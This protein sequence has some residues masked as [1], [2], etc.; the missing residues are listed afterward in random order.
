MSKEQV[1]AKG[2]YSHQ[3][4]ETLIGVKQYI[5]VRGEDGKKRLLLR[6][7]NNRQE[8]CSKFVFILSRLDSKGK[9]LGEERFES[10]NR[11]YKGKETFSFHQKID[12]E[13]KCTDFVVRM[14]YARYGEYVH[15]VENNEVS[16]SYDN[17]STGSKSKKGIGKLKP[18][19]ISGRSFD[20][21]WFFV[22]ISLVILATAFAITGFLLRDYVKTEKDFSLAGVHYKFKDKAK[23]EVEIVGCSDYYR[24]IELSSVIEDDYKVVGIKE[25]AFKKNKTLQKIS[26]DGINIEPEAFRGCTK[27]EAVSISNVSLIGEKAFYGCSKLKSITVNEGK[28]A[29]TIAI[30]SQAFGNCKELISVEINQT[31]IYGEKND[32]LN[33]SLKV[34]E[35]KLKNFAYTMKD[36]KSAYVTKISAL[37]GLENKKASGIKLKSL[38]IE[39]I[40]KIPAYFVTGFESLE[41]VTIKKSEIKT[42]GAEAFKDCKA[43]TKLE[44]KQKIVEIGSYA[45]SNT[46]IAS[47]DLKNVSVLG[48]GVFKGAEY[49]TQANGLGEGGITYIPKNTFEGCKKLTSFEI[50]P[51]ITQVYR[52]AFKGSGLTSFYLPQNVSFSI[53]ILEDCYSLRELKIHELGTAGFVGYFFGIADSNSKVSEISGKVPVALKTITLDNGVEI[54]AHAFKGCTGVERIKLPEGVVSFGKYAFAGCESL[55][56]IEIP[57][58]TLKNIG[59]YAF[60][61]TNLE[62]IE[63]P[64][65]LESI[66]YGALNGCDNLR[67]ITIPFLGGSKNQS[68]GGIGYI[69]GDEIPASL[70]NISLVPNTQ[71]VTLPANAFANCVG[72]TTINIPSS[73]TI[74]GENAFYNCQK[75]ANVDLSQVLSIGNNAFDGCSSLT[76]V[77]LCSKLINVG[78]Y[79]FKDTGLAYIDIPSDVQVLGKGILQGCDN[80]TSLSAPYLGSTLTSKNDAYVSYFFGGEIGY[81]IP[82]SLTSITITKPFENGIIPSFAFYNCKNVVNFGIE[83]GYT[84]I[85]ESAFQNCSS[86]VS[87]DFSNI[88]SIGSAAFCGAGIISAEF[89]DT[90]VSLGAYSFENCT[91]LKNVVLPNG[92]N[93]IGSNT[94]KNTGI[95]KIEIPEGVSS[96]GEYAFAQTKLTEIKIP[97]S[98]SVL[99]YGAFEGCND[100]NKL[101]FPYTYGMYDSYLNAA[102][103]LFKASFPSSLKRVVINKTAYSYIP[104]RAFSYSYELEEVIINADI[105]T[106]ESYTFDGCIG[107]RYVEIPSSVYN[108]DETAF[109]G[110][111]HLYEINANGNYFDAGISSV[112]EYTNG[113][114]PTVVTENGYTFSYLD[115][116]W[117]LVNYPSIKDIE[118]DTSFNY[119]GSLITEYSIP[120]YL[121]YDDDSIESVKLSASV[122]GIGEAIFT[123]CQSLKTV[124][125]GENNSISAIGE[126]T[127]AYCE[128]LTRVSLPDSVE[129]IGANAFEECSNLEEVVFPSSLRRIGSRAF[130]DCEKLNNVKLYEKVTDIGEE[131]FYGC[132]NLYDVY[133]NGTLSLTAG[134]KDNGYVARNAV[135]VH[136]DMNE[137][138]SVKVN[139]DGIGEFRRSGSSWLLVEG[140][141]KKKIELDVFYYDDVKVSEYRIKEGAFAYHNNIEEL[142]IG[143]SV[144]QIQGSAF[145]GCSNIKRIDMSNNYSLKTIEYATFANCYSLKYAFLP[146][147]V[148]TLRDSVF[149]SCSRLVEVSMPKNLVTIG[150]YVF[151]G[152]SSLVSITLNEGVTTIGNY[153][154]DGCVRLYEV[155]DLSPSINVR[156]GESGNGMVGE[157]A[158]TVFTNTNQALARNE[159]DGMKFI[160]TSAYWYLYDF[161]DQGMELIT[162]PNLE[163]SIVILNYSIENGTFKSIIMPKNI[164]SIESNAFANCISFVSIYYKGN[165]SDWSYVDDYSSSSYFRNLYYYSSCVHYDSYRAWTYDANGS[166]T[167]EQCKETMKVTKEPDCY[168]TGEATYYCDCNGCSYN[169]RETIPKTEH[170]FENGIC[171]VCKYQ[172]VSFDE[173][174]VNEY[175][176]SGTLV[177]D[178]FAY[179]K[180]NNRFV[181]LNKADLSSSSFVITAKEKMTVSFKIQASSESYDYIAIYVNGIQRTS[182][183]AKSSSVFE[184]VLEQGDV[185][186][187]SYVK[188]QS[189]SKYDDCGYIENFKVIVKPTSN[190]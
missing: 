152:C 1:L 135:K 182:V 123:S 25:G 110:C 68:T 160:K 4:P 128:N 183:S 147:T 115:G 102:D 132:K 145:V 47:I 142:I 153:S 158:D 12:V 35:L 84:K 20:M 81:G 66:G 167:T 98:V 43:F 171:T 8:S 143:N 140:V 73:I 10:D 154:F 163:G 179:D 67:Y 7:N 100:L 178:D 9:V 40:D 80:I 113:K 89:D 107:L 38:E 144:K 64:T 184:E 24:E 150:S 76:S 30:G 124:D 55:K 44:G 15:N 17:A 63:L 45:F 54:N 170:N 16:V 28:N 180:E 92:L 90:L 162:F 177:L 88:E 134:E 157:Y 74:I 125:F 103:Y 186:T 70:T 190:D 111:Y 155:Y 116:E 60:Y 61:N 18:R 97:S 137:P 57:S 189:E 48:T 3:Q 176:S 34:E 173:S 149:Y 14:I 139:I 19:K 161:E 121:F 2:K 46:R 50:N 118:P 94:F 119:L 175:L 72:A 93:N 91:S 122:N 131:A 23:K 117:Y 185:L 65:T 21:P 29:K 96:I 87:F 130:A 148:E 120:S 62:S 136:T 59:E 166:P 172:L 42:I 69:F 27:L 187:V 141:D 156:R 79:A 109:E 105:S 11:E 165:S 6:F 108:V 52:E 82:N 77:Q 126:G 133:S 146:T 49:L 53:G 71:M 101:E 138:S 32:F 151:Q 33:E 83:E 127:F 51:K 31:L 181:S 112:I 114:A 37:Y 75:L 41:R 168:A 164:V 56:T 36:V 26:I 169:R 85:G 39:N 13:E 159:K 22:V 104:S 5:F 106:I 99:G 86:L 174:T 95:T 188:D 58:T 129:I 78:N